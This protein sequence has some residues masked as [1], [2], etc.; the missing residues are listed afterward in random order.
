MRTTVT[1]DDDVVALIEDERRRTGESF[2]AAVNRLLRHGAP[3][4]PWQEAAPLPRHPGRPLLDVTDVSRLLAV[5]DDDRRMER[6][7]P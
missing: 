7:L 1:L 4:A 5:L 3:P 2:H 6:D